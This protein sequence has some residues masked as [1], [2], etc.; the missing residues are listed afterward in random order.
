VGDSPDIAQMTTPRMFDAL[1]RKVFTLTA[2]QLVWNTR[3]QSWFGL[4]YVQNVL[5]QLVQLRRYSHWSR[6]RQW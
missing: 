3:C 5:A 6:F 4:P 1:H 2:F